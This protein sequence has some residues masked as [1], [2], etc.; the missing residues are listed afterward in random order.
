[1]RHRLLVVLALMSIAGCP[2][3]GTTDAQPTVQT[4]P[5][6]Q[7][8]PESQPESQPEPEKP[9]MAGA[10]AV[11]A[12]KVQTPVETCAPLGSSA[13][14]DLST[15]LAL[16]R[17]LSCKPELF[18][19]SRDEI[20][21]TLA[22]PDAVELA[23]GRRSASIEPSE[24]VALTE[25]LAAAGIAE[26]KLRFSIGF[27]ST[28]E[29]VDASGELPP[30]AWGVGE[31]RV[32][33]PFERGDDEAEP[34]NGTLTEITAA[35]MVEGPIRLY[36]PETALSF[37]PDPHAATAMLLSLDALAGDPS[38]LEREGDKA[39]EALTALGE[40]Y[41]IDRYSVGLGAEQRR[42]FSLRPDRTELIASDLAALL[43][44]AKPHHK[45]LH[46]TDTNPNRLANDDQAEF[47]WRGL[48]LEIELH[49]REGTHLGLAGW[50]V[51]DIVVLPAA[52]PE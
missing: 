27:R 25:L 30:R 46:I 51:D 48:E 31:L 8:K 21:K 33:L 52:K 5:A 3:S 35:S 4:K 40:R 49:E 29:L 12:A 32:A 42:G 7:T 44:L 34:G 41:T 36:I 28:W 13:N 20:R 47:E 19:S 9:T 2:S 26:A 37:E 10:A 45:T 38:L 11:P 6:P 18:G 50:I 14:A 15:K 17:E 43:G 22:V 23:I 16:L 39:R 24:P 1:M